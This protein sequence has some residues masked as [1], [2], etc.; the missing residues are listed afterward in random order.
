MLIG[1]DDTDSLNGMCTTYLA[2]LLAEKLKVTGFPRLIRLNPNIPYRTRG[3]GAIALHVEDS[4]GK[5]K[6]IVLEMVEK[7]ARMEDENTNPGVVF[8]RG[9]N[10]ER[11]KLL[12][13]F[14]GRAVSELVKI[15]D[16]EKL[17]AQVDAEVHKFKNG[18]GIIGAL[19]AAGAALP[20]RT[21]EIIAYRVEKNY[22]TDRKIDVPSI[23]RMDDATYPQTFNN[24]DRETGQVMIMPHGHD[25]ILCGI[26]G[27][28]PQIVTRAW[29]MLSVGEE[30]ERTIV[31]ETNQG[32]D[33]HFREKKITDLK[34]YDCAILSGEVNM[35]P[36]TIE[37]GHVIFGFSDGTGKIACAAYEPTGGFRD[38]VRK[39]VAGDQLTVSGSIGSYPSTLNLEKI[40]ITKLIKIEEKTPPECCGKRMT[41]AGS[42]KGFKCKKCGKKAGEDA[43]TT[44][45]A[46]RGLSLGFY[47]VP[48]RARRHLNK[49]MVLSQPPPPSSKFNSLK[50]KVIN[51]MRRGST[52]RK[53]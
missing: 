45:E 5:T 51:V 9:M 7:Y 38:V 50:S 52:E 15:E 2:A 1:I 44:K 39:L 8:I 18:R 36:Q 17:A 6:K 31:F 4:P 19:A 14:Y 23:F 20:E 53:P 25:P 11:S 26:R 42:G 16:A 3:N 24:V 33:A 47:E 35:P 32:T 37:G 28:S 49:P 22:G 43:A 13:E 21:Y 41:S 34:P 30:V 10:P 40:N 48:V 46:E 29:K 12:E 27:R